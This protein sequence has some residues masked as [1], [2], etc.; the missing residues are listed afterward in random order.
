MQ[1]VAMSE[2]TGAVGLISGGL[3]STV[4]ASYM[5]AHYDET[6]YLFVDY[7]QKTLDREL[8]A[9][10]ELTEV[11]QPTS[12]RVVDLRWM[13]T[14]GNSALFEEGTT[15]NAENR[16]RE[17]VPFRNANLLA[18]GV[19]LAE[20]LEADALLIGSTGTDRTCP[21]NSQPFLDA[22]QGVIDLGTMTEKRIRIVA[23]LIELDKKGVIQL[24]L[25]LGAPFELSWSCHN[26]T[27]DVACGGCSNC[28]ARRQGFIDLGRV[29]PIA[30]EA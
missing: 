8:R 9:F 3:D 19:A 26:N 4:V 5:E 10:R 2:V 25:D 18:A 11:L 28:A 20:T 15:L 17:Y 6:H 1:E 14:V 12:A 16:K 22:F 7:G 30:Y 24:G 29:D 23:P 27:H 21:D 13:R